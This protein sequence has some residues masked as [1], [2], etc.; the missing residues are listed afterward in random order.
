MRKAIDTN[1]LIRAMVDEG[2]EENKVAFEVLSTQPLAIS[3]TV[4]L[5][6]EWV[7]RSKY[8]TSRGRVANLFAKLLGADNLDIE[9]YDAVAEALAAHSEGMDFADALHVFRSPPNCDAFLTFDGP[10]LSSARRIPTPLPVVRPSLQLSKD[11]VFE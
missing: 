10:F 3:V 6:A 7:L 9:D 5:E 4:L 11:Q 2:I 8:K 1:I